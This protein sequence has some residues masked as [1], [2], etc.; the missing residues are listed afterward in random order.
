[1]PETVPEAMMAMGWPE[2]SKERV[3]GGILKTTSW[4][5]AGEG[6]NDSERARI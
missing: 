4:A 3:V 2:T 6:T 1:M 5:A